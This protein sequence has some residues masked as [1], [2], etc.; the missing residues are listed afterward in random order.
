[1]TLLALVDPILPYLALFCH[2]LAL[3]CFYLALLR[4]IWPFWPYLT[5]FGPYLTLFGII[6]PRAF[7]PMEGQSRI[8]NVIR[9]LDRIKILI[10]PPEGHL[11]P[12]LRLLAHGGPKSDQKCDP[13]PRSDQNLDQTTGGPCKPR[14]Q[15]FWPMEGQSRIKNAIRPLDRIK[16][17]I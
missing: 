2:I 6:L 14:A 16:M 12:G 5:L 7:R 10:R 3:F 4:P 8:K 1:L 15:T 9:P 17:P 11:S 13:T